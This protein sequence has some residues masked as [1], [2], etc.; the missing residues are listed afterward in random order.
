MAQQGGMMQGGQGGM[1]SQR[2]MVNLKDPP[3]ELKVES[4]RYSKGQYFVSTAAGDI[5][6]FPELNL[7]IKTDVSDKG[8]LSGKPALAPVGMMGDR[9]FLV[10]AQPGEISGYINNECGP[11]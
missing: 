7:R 4:V 10:F 3:P 8:P 2:E 6:E 5:L 1:M 11:S 9:A